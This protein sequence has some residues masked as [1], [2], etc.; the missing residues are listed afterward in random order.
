M[1]ERTIL[2]AVALALAMAACGGDEEA[3]DVPDPTVRVVDGELGEH[4]ADYDRMSLYAFDGDV[5]GE[6]QC[7][8]DCAEQ[9]PPFAVPDEPSAGDGVDKH[10]LGTVERE[11]GLLQ[12]TFDDRPLYHRDR[13][14]RPGHAR[15]HGES[16]VWWLL[17]PDGEPVE[18]LPD[19]EGRGE[20]QR[21]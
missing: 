17:R 13:D 6:S 21:R 2:L 14:E 19:E 16:D 12:V 4:L 15:G 7:Y 5:P 11:D 9:W 10:R 20:S 18:A 3:A 8:E 1:P